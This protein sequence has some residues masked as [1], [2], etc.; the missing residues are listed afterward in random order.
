MHDP[1]VAQG[2]VTP[3]RSAPSGF[4]HS[5]QAPAHSAASGA[6][7]RG[8]FRL[9]CTHS[10]G[11]ASESHILLLRPLSASPFLVPTSDL[12]SGPRGAG[13]LLLSEGPLDC[14][15]LPVGSGA[16]GTAP[17]YWPGS[18]STGRL[19]VTPEP[20][21]RRSK[22]S[23]S[24]RLYPP[25]T[26]LCASPGHL[27]GSLTRPPECPEAQ[28]LCRGAASRLR[29]PRPSL[30]PGPTLPRVGRR[31]CRASRRGGNATQET[32]P[33]GASSG[34]HLAVTNKGGLGFLPFLPPAS[35]STPFLDLPSHPPPSHPQ[36]PTCPG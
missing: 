3:L 13:A 14:A 35:A 22:P 10:S 15:A 16:R 29:K 21:W 1:P 9:T 36:P 32:G 30:S 4:R 18:L 24:G 19:P 17:S 2:G 25:R 20:A 31:G 12:G 7:P 34:C 33:L 6:Q 27:S 11:G 8:S 5:C 26:G 23:G 28:L